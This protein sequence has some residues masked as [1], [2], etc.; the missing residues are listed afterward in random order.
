MSRDSVANVEGTVE[1]T[2]L[3]RV[4]IQSLLSRRVVSE[5]I[6]L[7]LYKRAVAA[8]R[9][10]DRQFNPPYAISSHGVA[11][12]VTDVSTLLHS[13]SL[14]VIRTIDQRSDR[15]F[16]VLR[17]LDASEVASLATDLNSME[18]EYLRNLIESIV[19][20]YPANSLAI[21]QA[22]DVINDS[23]LTQHKMTKSHAESLLDALVSR[24]WLYKSKRIRFSLGV[25]ALAELEIY[26][27]NE[28]DQYVKSCAQCKRVVTEGIACSNEGCDCHIHNSCYARNIQRLANPVCPICLSS[29]R[30]LAPRLVGEK[31]VSTMEDSFKGGRKKK[32]RGKNLRNGD[33]E[34]EEE[35]GGSSE[36][37]DELDEQRESQSQ[38]QNQE[39]IRQAYVPETQYEEEP[40]TSAGP[41]KRTRRR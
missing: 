5:T 24:G 8:V 9:A 22:R 35:D 1:P 21:G 19:V 7:E 17:N 26:L 39:S 4:F 34:D 33:E 41:S 30:D 6:A 13:V 15:A 29:F 10:Y 40:S 16:F 20:S 12:F 31:S 18:I 32:G 37:E 11:S 36:A 14:E 25:R 28:F 3:H 38:A 2:L 23:P 27:K